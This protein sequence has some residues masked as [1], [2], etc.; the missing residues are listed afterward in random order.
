MVLKFQ[1]F[2]AAPN[3]ARSEKPD[4]AEDGEDQEELEQG[5]KM[6]NVRHRDMN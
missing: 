2:G 3:K 6:Q 4:Q 1:T 5:R